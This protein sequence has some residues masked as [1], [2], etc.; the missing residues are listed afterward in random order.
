M[1]AL[2]QRVLRSLIVDLRHDLE[3]E[4]VDTG[5]N[6]RFLGL[7]HEGGIVGEHC[8]QIGGDLVLRRLMATYRLGDDGIGAPVDQRTAAP[9]AWQ[10]V[11]RTPSS[12]V[13]CQR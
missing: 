12:L 5:S 4:V 10:D 1:C 11:S 6:R 8:I 2:G 9:V 3:S 7:R 13:G